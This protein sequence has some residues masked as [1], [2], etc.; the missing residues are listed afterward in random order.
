MNSVTYPPIPALASLSGRPGPRIRR[1]SNQRIHRSADIDSLA[2]TGLPA[3]YTAVA[4]NAPNIAVD[5]LRRRRLPLRAH[6]SLLR[7]IEAAWGLSPLTGGDADGA[8]RFLPGG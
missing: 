1:R 2:A 3:T 5:R 4:Q 6:Y 8:G 7:T